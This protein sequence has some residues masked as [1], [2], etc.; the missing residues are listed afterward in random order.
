MAYHILHGSK[1]ALK[2][3]HPT[4]TTSNK[5]Q[6]MSTSFLCLAPTA[7][8]AVATSVFILCISVQNCVG[9]QAWIITMRS[10]KGLKSLSHILYWL[11]GFLT[12]LVAAATYIS[13]YDHDD[14]YYSRR[15]SFKRTCFDE[16]YV[17]TEEEASK[18]ASKTFVHQTT[19][20]IY[21]SSTPVSTLQG[22]PTGHDWLTIITTSKTRPRS[23]IEAR[24]RI[25]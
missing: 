7:S 24:R 5:N 11:T 10:R 9:R 19:I 1:K 22:N 16:F 12:Q 8:A 4:N 15:Y 20:L 14:D 6:A 2:F 17:R 13:F 21:S 25:L 3:P 23:S 18:Q